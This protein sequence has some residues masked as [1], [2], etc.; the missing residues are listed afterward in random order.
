MRD[1]GII[2]VGNFQTYYLS[3]VVCADTVR[4]VPRLEDISK[5]NRDLA[6]VSKRQGVARWSDLPV[7]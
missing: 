7:A 4:C 1:Y 6:C 3:N 5:P 2:W